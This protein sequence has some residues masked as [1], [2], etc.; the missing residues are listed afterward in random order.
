MVPRRHGVYQPVG[1]TVMPGGISR[2]L[3]MIPPMVAIAEDVRELCPDAHF[4]NYSNPMTAICTAVRRATGV[5]LIGL[6]HGMHVAEGY[7]ARFLGVPEGSVSTFGV[8]LNHLTFLTHIFCRGEDA[9]PR[10]REL[11]SEQRVT[12]QEEIRAKDEFVNWVTGRAPRYS[13][14]PFSW[15]FYEEHGVFP[16]MMD[17]HASEFFPERFPGGRYFGKTLG[18]DAYPI[19]KRIA[20]GDEVYAEFVRLARAEGPLP[21]DFFSRVPGEHEQLV[22]IMTSLMTD[23]RQVFSVNMPNAGAVPNLPA[24]AVLELPAAATARGF[25]Q[26]H[27]G[28]LPEQLAHIL[29]DKLEATDLTV[30]AALTGSRDLFVEALVRDGAVTDRDAASRL[31]DDL[32]SA[33][34][35]HLPHFFV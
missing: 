33:H 24:E 1:D 32:L 10:L 34:R 18:V 29:R 7:L 15:A 13:D 3:R 31:A 5:P 28:P 8:G 14:D 6:C 20:W 16:I 19:D 23:E 27:A 11:L 26:L 25:C 22:E 4:F 2:A 35:E 9:G 12:L 30:Q 17:R 21:E